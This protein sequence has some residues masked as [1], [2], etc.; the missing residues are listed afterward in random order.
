M[1]QQ[2]KDI[3]ERQ[4]RCA[5]THTLSPETRRELLEAMHA[6]PSPRRCFAAALNAVVLAVVLLGLGLLTAFVLIL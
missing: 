2:A 1:T 6:G 5:W 4:T 3:F